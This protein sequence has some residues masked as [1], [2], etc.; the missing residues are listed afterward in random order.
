MADTKTF[1]NL[2]LAKEAMLMGGNAPCVL[3]AANEVVVD[4]FLK[5]KVGF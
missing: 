4:A 1:R 3:N 5:N 2:A